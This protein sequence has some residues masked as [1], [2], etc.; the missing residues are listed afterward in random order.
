MERHRIAGGLR[1]V[2]RDH[3]PDVREGGVQASAASATRPG[4]RRRSPGACRGAGQDDGDVAARVLAVVAGL[5]ADP[6][7]RR[8]TGSK[9]VEAPSDTR[10]SSR[11]AVRAM[12]VSASSRERSGATCRPI[13]AGV[14]VS[15]GSPSGGTVQTRVRRGPA[16]TG[17][18]RSPAKRPS[19]RRGPPIRASSR[20]A[21]VLS[22]SSTAPCAASPTDSDPWD[23]CRRANR[24]VVEQVGRAERHPVLEPILAPVVDTREHAGG[25]RGLEGAAHH[26]TLV[27]TPGE[28]SRR[29]RHSGA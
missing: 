18:R 26:D 1:E 6:P 29:S 5:V 17:H 22:L 8:H 15:C 21:Q 9:P 28:S 20:L 13:A 19:T 25:E 24:S 27:G 2:G 12:L 14:V 7:T 11:R 4:C 16:A 3:P 23:R 10:P